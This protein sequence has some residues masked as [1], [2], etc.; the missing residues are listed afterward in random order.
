MKL[1]DSDLVDHRV[2]ENGKNKEWELNIDLSYKII[3]KP[4]KKMT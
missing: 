1:V 3:S 2:E 4:T